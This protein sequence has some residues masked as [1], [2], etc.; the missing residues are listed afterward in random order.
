MGC[1]AI[2]KKELNQCAVYANFER[3]TRAGVKYQRIILMR[4][5]EYKA[6]SPSKQ[7]SILHE[8]RKEC[9][10]F[11]YKIACPPWTVLNEQEIILKFRTDLRLCE[12]H[13]P[14]AMFSGSKAPRPTQ[15]VLS[16]PAMPSSPPTINRE[17]PINKKELNQC[18]VYVNLEH[19]TRAGVKYHR[20]I[21]LRHMEYKAASPSKQELILREIRKECSCFFYKNARSPWTVLNE[22]EIILK[23]RT[24]LR[25]CKKPAPAMLSSPPTINRKTPI[26]KKEL[27]Q[28][29]VY[30]NLEHVTLA[31]VKYQRIILLRHMEYKAGS[32][33]K[34]ESI[35]RE[36][37]KA[38]SCFFHKSKSN[39]PPWTVLDEQE[40]ILKFRTALCSCSRK[41]PPP[42]FMFSK[43]KKPKPTRNV[44][45]SSA[46]LSSAP[47]INGED[48]IKDK[49]KKNGELQPERVCS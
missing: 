27:S 4:H 48:K 33:S 24:A 42:V 9:S 23:F 8:I 35:L 16:S 15:D 30:A 44:V 43:S 6:A 17:T 21:L 37:R 41:K 5:T 39:R 31:G 11:F 29:D 36:I 19:A 40:I 34:K 12:E 46:M 2:N 7:E 20:T 1:T 49:I 3:A 45:S 22:Q 47:T 32:P 10:C 25:L 26:N 28:H 38:C 14:V 18:A 13:P